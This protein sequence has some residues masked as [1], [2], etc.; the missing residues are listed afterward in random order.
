MD[1]HY[2]MC[3]PHFYSTH[4]LFNP[5]MDYREEVDKNLAI[6]QWN[7]LKNSI[8]N[9]GGNIA[10]IFPSFKDSA[11]VFVRD[12]ALVYDDNKVLILRSYG[13]RGKR[14]PKLL[15]KW[16]KKNGWQVSMLPEGYHL[17]GGNLVWASSDTI[18]YG[19]K[20]DELLHGLKWVHE[21]LQSELKKK[22]K[23]V[24]L[25]LVNKRYLHLDMLINSL[26]GKG[27]L[28]YPKGLNLGAYWKKSKIWNFRPVIELQESEFFAAN[29]VVVNRTVIT[30]TLSIETAEKI[31]KLGFKVTNVE[32][33]EFHKAGGGAH[34]LTLELFPAWKLYG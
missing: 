3:P 23:V 30:S 14:E 29:A 27:F 11:M 4:F 16:F 7:S 13:Q 19:W 24:L 17:E 28:V 33:S 5:W 32:L 26:N 21:F 15:Y 10:E 2:L 8:I 6:S 9:A 25:R 34:C 1:L 22:I 12:N 31:K 20:P 18:F